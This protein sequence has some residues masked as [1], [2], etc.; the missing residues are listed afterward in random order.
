MLP[1]KRTILALIA[2]LVFACLAPA[3]APLT[4]IQD[5]LFSA[6]G[7]LFNGTLTI[8]WST[9]D[10]NSGTVVQQS[11]VVAVVNGNLFVQLAANISATPPANVYT[12]TYLSDSSSQFSETW[13]VPSSTTPLQVRSVRTSTANSSTSGTANSSSGSSGPIPESGVTNLVSDL[14]Q[15]PV[16]GAAFGT[17][18]VAVVDNTGTLETAVGQAGDCVLVDGTTGPCGAPS[19]SDAETP[20]GTLDGVNAAFTLAYVPLGNSLMLFRNGIY[21]TSGVDYAL[22][23]SQV[24]FQAGAVPQPGDVL[25]ASYRVD[26]TQSSSNPS[27]AHPTVAVRASTAAQ[28]VCNGPGISTR[29]GVWTVIGGCDIPAGQ[30][31]NG[32]RLEVRYTLSHTGRISGFDIE[33]DWGPTAIIA[34]HGAAQDAAIVGTADAAI[35]AAGTLV[36]AQSWGTVTPVL[37]GVVSAPVLNGVAVSVKATTGTSTT[38]TVTLSSF[39]ILRYPAN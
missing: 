13:T 2:P 5:T 33:L 17:N 37:A 15:R 32:D 4:T 26:V 8:Q 19:Y 30:L 9:F 27:V 11:K 7:T 38:D 31:K 23:G 16:K 34:R 35:G 6:D 10:T 14:A 3:Q 36:T 1:M 18:A 21:Q 24:T 28:V 25:I 12:V 29:I 22:A 20:G 39:T